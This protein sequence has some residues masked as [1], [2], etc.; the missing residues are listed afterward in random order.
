MF[1]MLFAFGMRTVIEE[2]SFHGASQIVIVSLY[3]HGKKFCTPGIFP[4]F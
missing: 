4:Q 3:T 2:F 1:F